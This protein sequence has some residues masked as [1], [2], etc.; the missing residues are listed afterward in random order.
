MPIAAS[1]V[2]FSGA[3]VM[4]EVADFAREEERALIVAYLRRMG[5]D[6]DDVTPGALA[7]LIAEGDHAQG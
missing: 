5:A 2:P 4:Q 6:L 3:E 7:D 1:R